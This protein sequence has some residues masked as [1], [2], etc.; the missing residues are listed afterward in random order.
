MKVILLQDVQG[1]GKKGE[2]KEVKDGYARNMLL[3]KGL[4]IEATKANLT[5]LE[6]KKASAQH[7]IDTARETAEKTA[8]SLS[9]KIIKVTARAGDDGRLFGS[10]T[11]KDVAAALC[12]EGFDIDKKKLNVPGDIKNCGT[13]EAEAKLYSG[14]NAKFTLDVTA[15][16]A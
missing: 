2:I 1:T 3:P 5:M 13:Y 7:K 6:Q 11:T 15:E 12:K 8:N 10:V 14:V 16:Q 4:A 9:G